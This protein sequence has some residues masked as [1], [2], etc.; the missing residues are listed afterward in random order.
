MEKILVPTDFSNIANNALEEAVQIAKKTQS[1]IVLLSVIEEGSSASV[2]VTGE[3]MHKDAEANIFMIKRIEKVKQDLGEIIDRYSDVTIFPEIRLG[4]PYHSITE[5][6]SEH[7]VDMI[8]MG[9][10]GS[11]GIEELV[12]GSNTEKVVRHAKCP[13]L[14]VHDKST[15][16]YENI[17]F[18]SSL[19]D[20]EEGLIKL[21]KGVQTTYHSKLHLVWVNTPNNFE[22]DK[23]TKERMRRFMEKHGLKDCTLNIF[24]D[25][26]EDDGI[27]SF[28]E[29]QKAD[30]IAMITHG[31]TGFA[32]LIAGSIAEDVVN[33]TKRPVLTYS[34]NS[35]NH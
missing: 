28:A 12:I 26:T 34:I 22:R 13:V 29:E 23:F 17:V 21:L 4:S 3:M 8:V 1:S 27:I 7:N 2:R 24:N 10:T 18:A 32:H 16:K 14:S 35:N 20:K 15:G 19:D 25:I 30:L 9:T 6:I 31:K 5:I 11:S 33:H